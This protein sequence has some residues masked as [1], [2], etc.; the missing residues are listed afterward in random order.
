MKA[1]GHSYRKGYTLVQ[2]VR[3]FG[4]DKDAEKWFINKRWPDDIRCPDCDSSRISERKNRKP[5][6]FR[7][8][9]CSKDF[10]VRTGTVMQSTK[11]GLS[12]W[13]IAMFLMSTNLK[14]VSSMKLH[15]DLGIT[16][17]SAWHLA[18]RIRESW[19][20]IK[21]TFGGTVEVDET[22]VGG[23]E[24]NKHESKKLRAGRGAVGKT[25][26]VGVKERESNQVSLEVVKR[27][28]K[29]TL[30][31]IIHR[32]TE[33]GA[34][35]YTDEARAYV[36]MNRHHEVVRHSAKEYVRGMVHTNGLESMWAMLQR[37]FVGVYHQMSRK[38]LF[39][40][41]AEFEGRHNHRPLDTEDH[42][43]AMVQGA[44]GKR[45]RYEDLIGP[46]Y[47]RLNGQMQLV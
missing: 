27:T 21:E 6:P 10:S 25:Q 46:W 47:T 17:K 36:G 38:H 35:V 2:A 31:S 42:M 34:V 14:G 33:P 8:R 9:A 13:A 11:L 37:G 24:K 12:K 16:Q 18:H 22:Y 29:A 32:Q 44:V 20:D 26:V 19:T 40:Y 30:Q 4:N 45:L 23:L 41:A 3:K 28:D 43:A 5:M 39:R 7:C 15:R 1:P